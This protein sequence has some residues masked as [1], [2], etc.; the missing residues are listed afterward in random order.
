MKARTIIA[1]AA[2]AAVLPF[3]AAWA[4][5]PTGPQ[6]TGAYGSPNG[7]FPVPQQQL[8]PY[9]TGYAPQYEG[10]SA[11]AGESRAMGSRGDPRAETQTPQDQRGFMGGRFT[12]GPL[13]GFSADTNP[14]A[15]PP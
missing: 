1:C 10:R 15:P 11:T 4:T 12:R 5:Q 7:A 8:D 14:P 13:Q 3:T 2:T 6:G 9:T